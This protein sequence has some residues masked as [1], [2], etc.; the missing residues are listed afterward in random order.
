MSTCRLTISGQAGG[1]ARMA[2]RDTISNR[3]DRRE[4]SRWTIVKHGQAGAVLRTVWRNVPRSERET[5]AMIDL[6]LIPGLSKMERGGKRAGAGRK[7]NSGATSGRDFAEAVRRVYAQLG[8]DAAFLAWAEQHQ[9]VVEA[10]AAL[11]RWL[12]AV[13]ARTAH[14]AESSGDDRWPS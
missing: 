11:R 13:R 3:T 8:G 2:L 12:Q 14:T 10:D 7:K 6:L 1:N 4:S 5:Y 9:A